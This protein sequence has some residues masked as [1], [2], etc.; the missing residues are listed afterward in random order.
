MGAGF[1][2][3]GVLIVV[4]SGA[5]VLY[6]NIAGLFGVVFGAIWTVAGGGTYLRIRKYEERNFTWFRQTYPDSCGAK[7]QISCISC[8]GKRISIRGLKQHTYTREHFC[9]TCGLT[10]YY[11][12]E[13]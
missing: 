6:G 8:Q 10:L 4:V 13:G 7:G 11:S 12:P 2:L 9:G 5:Y 1:G 3:A